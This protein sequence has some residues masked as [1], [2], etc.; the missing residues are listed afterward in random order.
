M[1]Q[2]SKIELYHALAF[3]L[4]IEN[5][6]NFHAKIMK[7]NLESKVAIL[8]VKIQRTCIYKMAKKLKSVRIEFLN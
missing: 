5:L 1:Q 2:F 6:L 3:S 7:F 8:L 4:C